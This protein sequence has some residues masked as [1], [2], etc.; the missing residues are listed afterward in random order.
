VLRNII[1]KLV[2]RVIALPYCLYY[3]CCLWLNKQYILLSKTKPVFIKG[4]V[5]IVD[6]VCVFASFPK[7][8]IAEDVFFYLE[9]LKDVGY[10]IVFV[11]TVLLDQKD[12]NKLKVITSTII[13]R[14]N[15]GAD[16]GSFK[17]GLMFI[18]KHSAKLSSITIANDSVIGPIH[19]LK[20]VYQE[21]Q[22]QK[23]DFWGITE[24]SIGSAST[25]HLCS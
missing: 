14:K 21:M 19:P 9:S 12:L 8:G 23:C 18:K 22:N 11:S 10:A 16:F 25:Y 20:R 17:E 5:E 7:N 3:D 24:S 13:I 6:K 1:I 4:N 15:Y 2:K